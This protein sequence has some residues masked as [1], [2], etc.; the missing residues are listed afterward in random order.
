MKVGEL[1]GGEIGRESS[2]CH[3][4]VEVGWKRGEMMKTSN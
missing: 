4:V 2:W 3:L 1:G